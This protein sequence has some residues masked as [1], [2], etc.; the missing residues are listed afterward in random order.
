MTTIDT[1]SARLSHA[2]IH[3]SLLTQSAYRYTRF[4]QGNLLF[5]YLISTSQRLYKFIFPLQV[6]IGWPT[7][8]SQHFYKLRS[9]KLSMTPA[10]LR[11]YSFRT[12]L[13]SLIKVLGCTK[14]LRGSFF[15]KTIFLISPSHPGIGLV[16]SV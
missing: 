4:V 8:L 16:S 7:L 1:N 12:T 11:G 10:G 14:I 5:Q 15:C 3:L 2:Y 9:M 13:L 6:R